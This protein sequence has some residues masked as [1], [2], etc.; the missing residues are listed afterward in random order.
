MKFIISLILGLFL[1]VGAFEVGQKFAKF[2]RDADGKIGRM[3]DTVSI[4]SLQ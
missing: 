1:C 2:V 3:V 4:P